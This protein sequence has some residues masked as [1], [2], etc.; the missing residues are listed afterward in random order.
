MRNAIQQVRSAI[1]LRSLHV[2]PSSF[3]P[4]ENDGTRCA[5]A[6]EVE[7]GACLP[8]CSTLLA[9]HGIHTS[10]APALTVAVPAGLV[11]VVVNLESREVWA[12]AIFAKWVFLPCGMC[13]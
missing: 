5:I 8:I 2:H 4:V 11:I 1:L 3:Y 7:V 9:H 12:C 6:D 10:I 13:R